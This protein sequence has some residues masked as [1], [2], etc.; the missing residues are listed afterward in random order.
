MLPHFKSARVHV[1]H[2]PL[3]ATAKKKKKNKQT[4]KNVLTRNT[5]LG[6]GGAALAQMRC[7]DRKW[8]VY[9]KRKHTTAFTI[10]A[11]VKIPSK[12]Q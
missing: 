8:C 9:V 10:A 6:S 7:K 11:S 12:Y 5:K 3:Q 2:W 4:K 1:Q